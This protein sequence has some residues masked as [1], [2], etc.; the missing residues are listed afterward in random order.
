MKVNGTDITPQAIEFELKRLLRFYASHMSVEQMNGQMEALRRKAL[1]QAVGTQLL[2]EQVNRLDMPIPPAEVDEALRAMEKNA[3]GPAALHDLMV[4]QGLTPA[5]LRK[6]IE[7]G[8]KLDRLVA[9]ITSACNDPTEDELLAHF[10]AHQEEYQAPAQVE[11]SHILIKAAGAG[12]ADKQTARSRLQE[13][14]S[15]LMDGTDFCQEAAAHSECP[16]GTKS[17]GSLGWYSRGM[18]TPAMDQAAFA[19]EDGEISE[20]IETPLGFHVLKRVAHKEPQAAD[21]P[22]VAERIRDFLRHVRRGECIS[23]YVA[24]LREKAVIEGEPPR[25]DRGGGLG[26]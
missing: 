21:Y 16:S 10:K 9:Q 6:S 5:A 26:A 3:G 24:E 22:D 1:D 4:R 11:I 15:R 19:M 2:I 20:I 23:A 13:I 14:R 25:A 12:P 17:G 7:T 8:R 18:M